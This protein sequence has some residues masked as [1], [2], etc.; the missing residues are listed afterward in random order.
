MPNF[1]SNLKVFTF[2]GLFFVAGL[3]L[4][5]SVSEDMLIQ[6]DPAAINGKYFQ[7]S[8]LSS[9]QIKQ[10]LVHKVKIQTL[11]AGEKT[12]QLDGFSSA[13]CKSYSHIELTFEA[14]GVAVAGLPPSMTIKAPCLPGQDPANIAAVIIPFGKILS[15]KPRNAE[16]HFDG[17]LAKF[18]F[19]NSSDEWPKTWV[20][21]TVHFKSAIN[22]SK[23]VQLNT[24]DLSQSSDNKADNKLD[25]LIILEF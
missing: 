12:L 18:D 17:F 6:R 1:R 25:E 2:F 14:E 13:V 19:K 24:N 16:F 4:F 20:L 5:F 10:Q 7:L 21:K 22:G 11:A 23:L 8:N 3:A 15:E 9:S